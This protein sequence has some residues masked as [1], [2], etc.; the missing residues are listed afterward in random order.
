MLKRISEIKNIGRFK[1][2]SCGTLQFGELTLIFG[3]NT[4]GKSTLG[5]LLSSI[6]LNDTS[7]ISVRRTIPFDNNPQTATISFQLDNGNEKSISIDNNSWSPALPEPLKIAVYD[8]GF[9][10]NN[11]FTARQF[12]RSTKEK[13]ST[14]IL[15]AQGV[16]KAKE[17]AEKN[18][19]KRAITTEQTKLKKAAFSEIENLEA[20]LS[21]KP[22]GSKAELSE[23]KETKLRRYHELKKQKTNSTSIFQRNEFSPLTWF[24]DFV[25]LI[26]EIKMCFMTSLESHHHTAR[27]KLDEHIRINFKSSDGS[28]KWIREG[29]EQN[30]GENCQ[31]CGQKLT[32]STFSL[33]EIYRQSF[34][35]SFE[36][37]EKTVKTELSRCGESIFKNRTNQLKVH[38]EKNAGVIIAFP[39]LSENTRFTELI[40]EVNELTKELKQYID[41]WE[42]DNLIYQKQIG[43]YVLQKLKSPHVE[44]NATFSDS[45]PRLNDSIAKTV[46]EINIRG[47]EL[48]KFIKSFKE[49]VQSDKISE[50]IEQVTTDG[51]R[52]AKEINRIVLSDQCDEYIKLSGQFQSLS[53]ELPGLQA[54]LNDDQGSFLSSYFSKLNLHFQ[55]FGSK[56][57]TLEVGENRSGHMPIYY[58]KVKFRGKDISERELDRVFSESDRRA[59]SLAIFWARLSEISAEEKANTIV[60]LDDPVTSFDNNRI[61]AVH[62]SVIQLSENARQVIV[63]SHYE[64]ELSRFL[65]TY[66]NNKEIC[67]F[68]IAVKN[69]Q[70]T[71]C[72]ENIEKFI[73]NDHEKA[74]ENIFEFIEGTNNSNAI[75]DLRVFFEIELGMRFAKQIRDQKINCQNLS[76]RIDKL[77]TYNIIDEQVAQQCH[78]WR[79]ALNPSHHT[80]ENADIEDQRNT[81]RQFTDFIYNQL[82]PV[83]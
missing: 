14:F 20:F 30:Q 69:G 57:F 54:Q 78:V 22:S 68:S 18:K 56:E 32:D 44:V 28:E 26:E 38:I 61:S 62:R 8:D 55:D 49:S 81:A 16:A 21:L 42:K 52:L 59:L 4:Y 46:E 83:A 66:Q 43:G 25:A 65:T 6:S 80:W 17:I 75:G 60:V 48:N 41:N 7:D 47:V 45:L 53:Q 23:K 5:D 58:L 36:K 77:A 10:H 71:L 37:H 50:S 35:E 19:K 72:S 70:A 9:Y 73:K 2:A 29:L 40:C 33:F 34:D 27:R 51:K 11:V 31:F 3:R 63:L 24:N 82:K 67:L 13:F 74:R 15:G 79:E 12:T 1:N 64:Q 76:D 39:E